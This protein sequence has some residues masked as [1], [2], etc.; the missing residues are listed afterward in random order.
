MGIVFGEWPEE[1]HSDFEQV[2]RIESSKNLKKSVVSIDL[3]S[4]EVVIQGSGADP[5]RATLRECTCPDFSIRQAPC[6]HMY[7]LAGEMGFLKDLP[8]YKKKESS[9]DAELEIEKYRDLYRSGEIS[10][11][12]Y[13]KICA[14]LDK[15]RKKV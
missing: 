4:G 14:P 7:Y 12:S 11:D 2:K 15:M 6:K 8:V 9:F 5:Y 13:V 10:A 1:I 3:S